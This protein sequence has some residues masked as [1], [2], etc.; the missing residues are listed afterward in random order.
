MYV[1]FFK[2]CLVEHTQ[3]KLKQEAPARTKHLSKDAATQVLRRLC[4]VNKRTGKAKVSPDVAKQF[5]TGGEGRN[6]LIKLLIA[7]NGNK[8][9]PMQ[10]LSMIPIQ[11]YHLVVL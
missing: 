10:L 3:D 11:L 9:S 1:L 8:D 4:K 5:F 7:C 6:Q 2:T